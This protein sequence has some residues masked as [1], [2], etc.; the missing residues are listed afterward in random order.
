MSDDNKA[1]LSAV[2]ETNCA[3]FAGSIPE[4]QACAGFSGFLVDQIVAEPDA[5]NIPLATSLSLLDGPAIL[6]GFATGEAGI[7]GREI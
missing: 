4:S 6:L 7:A 1:C 3:P 5:D 2:S